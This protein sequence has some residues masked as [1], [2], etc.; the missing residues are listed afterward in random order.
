MNQLS[1]VVADSD[2][3]NSWLSNFETALSDRDT[4]ALSSLFADECHWRDLL[5]FTW[6]ITP[7][8]GREAISLG[9]AAAQ[10]STGARGFSVAIGRT[11]PRRLKRLGVD[12]IEAIFKFETDAG[13]GFGVLRLPASR[14]DVAWT[15]M[16]SLQELKGYE[17]PIGDRRPSGD[18][19]SRNFGG[20]NW[21]DLRSREQEF[22]ASDPAVLIIGAGQAGLTLA[23]RLRLLGV[24]TLVVDRWPRVGDVWRKRYHSLA[25][26][27]GVQLNH[28]AYMPFPPSWPNLLPKD[29]LGNWLEH[30]AWAMECNVW[31]GTDFL[32]GSYDED[33]GRWSARV[34]LADGSERLLRPRHLVFANG[35]SGKARIPKLPGLEDFKGEVIHTESYQA[36]ESWR[37]KR[38]IVL[39]AGTSGHDVAQD[40]HNYG[41][42]VKMIQRGS[43]TVVS[44]KSAKLVHAVYYDEGLSTADADLIATVSTY[45]LLIRGYQAAVKRMLEID[46]DLL[47]GLTKKGFKH[48]MGEDNTG[49]QMKFRRRHGGYYLDCGCADLIIGGQIGLT[50]W[51]DVEKFV[52]DGVRMRDGRVEKADL[53]VVATGYEPPSEVV[54]QLLGED[55]ATK[56]GHVW[57]I[58]ADGE[59]SNMFRPTPQKGLWFIGGGLAHAR[60]YSHFMALQIKAREVGLIGRAAPSAPNG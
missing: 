16:T 35:L 44:L 33:A 43:T 41:A 7:F 45:P 30:Y 11:P 3:V 37:G 15:L 21:S 26:H 59:L 54:R 31:S 55:I 14:P 24:P 39:G 20:D 36:G 46:R 28:M 27:N 49:H 53:L 48:D 34:R 50:Q 19:Y 1:T 8:E 18:A 5:A 23:A 32:E 10:A 40:L 47:E 51:E 56:V 25:L 52:P 29:M 57:G 42:I 12:V 13:R 60:I 58:A 2:L 22:A 9:L 38:A 4:G 6:S 17:E